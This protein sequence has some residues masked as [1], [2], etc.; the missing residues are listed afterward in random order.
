MKKVL[1]FISL[2]ISCKIAHAQ[3][4]TALEI[5][6]A[7]N[8]T[9]TATMYA[10]DNVAGDGTCGDL[11]SNTILITPGNQVNWTDYWQFT[12]SVG[13]ATATNP[14]GSSDY[15]GGGFQWTDIIVSFSS[16]PIGCTPPAN[17]TLSDGRYGCLS[18]SASVS[19]GCGPSGMTG[20]WGPWGSSSY[21]NRATGI[22][23]YNY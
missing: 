5:Q 4:Q 12:G 6:N 20:T 3:L 10:I 8:C 23:I 16:C 9:I 14:V 18:G 1:I 17:V 7:S 19:Y 15:G 11:V 13:W 21:P 2:C 22:G